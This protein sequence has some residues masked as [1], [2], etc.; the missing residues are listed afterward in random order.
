MIKGEGYGLWV[1]SWAIGIM[2]YHLI[3][4]EVPFTNLNYDPLRIFEAICSQ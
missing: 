3:T 1:D 2:T 4:G